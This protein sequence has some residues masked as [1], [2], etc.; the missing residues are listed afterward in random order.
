[1]RAVATLERYAKSAF[2]VRLRNGTKI[3]TSRYYQPTLR[4]LLERDEH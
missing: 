2:V 3:V 1:V 4:R